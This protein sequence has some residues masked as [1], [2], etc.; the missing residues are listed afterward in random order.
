MHWQL[1]DGNASCN[2]MQALTYTVEHNSKRKQKLQ[3]LKMVTGVIA[4][5][6]MTALVRYGI[7]HAPSK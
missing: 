2:A 6:Q 7:T 3:L 4:P 1:L 5:A